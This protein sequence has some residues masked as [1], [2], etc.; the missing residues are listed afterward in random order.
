[1][2][3]VPEFFQNLNIKLPYKPENPIPVKRTKNKYPTDT[4]N[5]RLFWGSTVHDREVAKGKND[6]NIHQ[7]MNNYDMPI[8]WN[9]IQPNEGMK[10]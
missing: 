3:I 5:T 9:I 7:P 2:K 10:Y 1:M 4:V 8:K 6:P